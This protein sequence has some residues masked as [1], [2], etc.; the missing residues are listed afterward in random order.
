MLA[1]PLLHFLL[2]EDDDNHAH[3]IMRSLKKNRIRNTFNRVSDG[4]AALDYLFARNEYADRQL[5]DVILLDLN[6][7]KRSGIEVLE[8]IKGSACLRII[9]VVM[10]T[11]SDAE[12]DRISAYSHHVN[13]YLV[14]PVDFDQFKTIVD[15][16]GY[17]WG[18]C[19]VPAPLDTS[20]ERQ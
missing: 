6:L 5:P 14:K 4:Q 20:A 1:N 10:L 11:T 18:I 2:V 19:N 3:L 8:L 15:D 9:P 12:R 17:Y 7:P 16:L 13:S